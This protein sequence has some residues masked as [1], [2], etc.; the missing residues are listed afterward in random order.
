[1]SEIKKN[2]KKVMVNVLWTGG[3]DS[4]FR[5]IQLST[6]D[7]IIQPFYLKD[8]RKS[9]KFELNT[10]HSLTEELRSLTSTKC[11]ICE[12]ITRNVSDIKEDND[13]TQA[14]KNIN[15][16]FK[17]LS[18]KKLGG[19]YDWL[20]RFSK[21]IGNLELS[22]EKG[23]KPID[24]ITAYGAIERIVDDKIGEYYIVNKSVS[25]KDIIKVFGNYHL[26]LL[27]YSKLRIKNEAE[28]NGFIDLMNKTWFCHTPIDNQPCGLC[29]P[30]MA[31][32][33]EGLD[34]R[35]SEVAL[36]RYKRKK[37]IN[38]VRNTFIYRAVRKIFRITKTDK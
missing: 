14:Y 26:P 4:T 2:K 23:T 35:F 9:E 8:N 38:P 15:K 12:V 22:I 5:I 27:A 13:I 20:A 18:K 28:E 29:N 32:I 19:Q 17:T 1:M 30:C 37:F 24:A 31:T 16:A 33:E 10:I 25:S 7:I 36:G 21:S 6:M 11:I 3:W 34:Y